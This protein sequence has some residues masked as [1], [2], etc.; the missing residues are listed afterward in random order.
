MNL[1]ITPPS[2]RYASQDVPAGLVVFLVALPLCLGI[3]LASGAPLFSG[4]I[5]GIVGGIVISLFS[6][7]E[8]SVSGPAAGLATVVASAIIS[9]GDFPTFLAAVVIAGLLQ[10]VIAA[11]KAGRLGDFIPH[12]VI[13][14]M[15]AAIGVSII[16]KQIPHSVGYDKDFLDE[17]GVEGFSQWHSIIQDP[18][19][20]VDA[21]VISLGAIAITLVC[22]GIMLVWEHPRVKAQRWSTIISGTLVAVV[23]GTLLNALLAAVAPDHAL[24]SSD[25]LV[26]LPKFD[27]A[28]GLSSFF[29]M[30]NFSAV[31]RFDVWATAL[32]IALIASIESILSVEAVDKMDPHKRIS[33]VNRELYAQGIGNTLSGL[34]GGLPVTSVI[35]RS[36]ANVYAGGRTRTSSFLH[37]VTL[38]VAV[39]LLPSVLNLI[40]LA[41]LA[42][43]LLMVGYKLASIKLLQN[44]WREGITQFA[45]FVITL[46]VIVAKD[47]LVG[48][49]VGLLISLFYV[50]KSYHRTSITTV[51]DDSTVLIRFNKDITFVHKALLKETLRD[52]VGG[53]KVIIDGTNAHYIDH[54][55]NELITDFVIAAPERNITVQTISVHGKKGSS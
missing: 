17:A 34:V 40:P 55:I 28:Q 49:G 53:S 1:R 23:S 33:D 16:L 18:I 20:M 35:V 46:V 13:K 2:F 51:R 36:S 8:L 12:S 6:G 29:T 31:S 37:G 9:L 45:P 39:I 3:A 30:P 50:I 25:H 7:S 10:L 44:M 47:I 24:V 14:G 11:S 5:A 54:D 19:A 48:V 43:V 41:C 21:G 38:L 26:N 32:T 22:L 27:P 15:L 52:I 42:A 4:I